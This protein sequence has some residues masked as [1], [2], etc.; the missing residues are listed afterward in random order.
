MLNKIFTYSFKGRS[1][2]TFERKDPDWAPSL[3]LGH[4]KL[5]GSSSLTEDQKSEE[6]SKH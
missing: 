3:K 5:K 2:A 4:K 6:K 1:S